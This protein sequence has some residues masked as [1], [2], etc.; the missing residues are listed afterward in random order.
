[1]YTPQRVQGALVAACLGLCAVLAPQ[2]A[3][4]KMSKEQ[5]AELQG[6]VQELKS[7]KPPEALQATLLLWGMV[8]ERK[9]LDELR[10]FKTHDQPHV[11]LAAGL[12]LMQ[13]ADKGADA[14]VRE[15]LMASADLSVSL[16]QVISLLDDKR[17]LKLLGELLKKASPETR[18]AILRYMAQQRGERFKSVVDLIE[19][20]D[21]GA[22]KDAIDA[23]AASANPEIS[24]YV[25]RLLKSKLEPAQVAGLNLG[26]ALIARDETQKV[27]VL[28]LLEQALTS[29]SAA[30]SSRALDE[31]ARHNHATALTML[32]QRAAQ[33]S[34][35]AQRQRDL[36]LLLEKV[37]AGH[38]LDKALATSLKTKLKQG[39][40]RVVALRLALRA[41]DL[42]ALSEAVSL[43]GSD[44][45]EERLV[46]AQVLGHSGSPQV[47]KLLGQGLFEGN[48]MMRLYCAQSL[49]VLAHESSLEPL[50]NA[51]QREKSPE[52]RVAVVRAIGALGSK[53]AF[54]LLQFQATETHM[55]VRLALLDA[56]VKLG[57]EDGFRVIE[58]MLRD[59][60]PK[61]QWSAFVAGLQLST[62]KTLAY[63][64][65]VL[66]DPPADY[67]MTLDKL[68]GPSRQEIFSVLMTHEGGARQGAA[69]GFMLARQHQA[70]YLKLLRDALVDPKT[71]LSIRRTILDGL[72]RAPQTEDFTIFEA[73]VRDKKEKVLAHHAALIL[74]RHAHRD[75]EATLRGMLASDDP[76][77]K[78]LAAYAL[79]VVF[80]A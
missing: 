1:M 58:I 27:K 37:M 41:G 44:S 63:K 72:A 33:S 23:L 7:A 71:K 61:L 22:R 4:A 42:D 76:V 2:A 66:R 78:A 67:L 21:E 19:G 31:L 59:R 35:E 18:Q 64:A 79:A 13:A 54:N 65:T 32:A 43:F 53:P 39:P 74:A 28:G 68:S 25:D 60:D 11:R 36:E 70:D 14:F 49:G 38:K 47:V 80:E 48:V 46:A 15:Q 57:F 12:A 3:Q 77:I 9:E 40:S 29:K 73:L 34:D 69:V 5:R 55:Q 45:Y 30:V 20:K 52:V 24:L 56:L 62:E 16:Q 75:H 8:A 26:L 51:L 17:E 6:A 50:Q 10:A